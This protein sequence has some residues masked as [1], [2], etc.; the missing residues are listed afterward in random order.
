MEKLVHKSE[1]RGKSNL[2]WLDSKHTF[3]FGSY[4]NEERINF[5][6][7]R[8]INDDHVAPGMGFGTHPHRDMEIISIPLEGD[9]EHKDSMGNKGIIKEGDIQVMSAGKGI[10]HSE[11][12]SN[13]DK[14]VKFLQ[15]WVIPNK[16]SVEP[17]YQQLSLESLKQENDFY[18]I[19]SPNEKD[20]GVWIHQNA[21]FHIGDL[22]KNESY[23]YELKDK[24][25][26]LYVFV[27]SGKIET[28]QELLEYRDGMGIKGIDTISF[29]SH[30]ESKVL[31]MEVPLKLY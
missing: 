14:P 10:T 13:N 11:F 18:Q 3:S 12:N 28:E 16:T 31:L 15:I 5:G 7:L 26:G 17:R 1:T 25:N 21:W 2:G 30:E 6:A 9:L 20:E 4:Q 24:S 22:K 8:V 23:S 29:K 27:I 19:L